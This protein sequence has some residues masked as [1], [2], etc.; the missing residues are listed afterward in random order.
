MCGVDRHRKT[1][2]NNVY[3]YLHPVSPRQYPNCKWIT[4]SNYFGNRSL[5]IRSGVV[6]TVQIY[7]IVIHYYD[8]LEAAATEG[9]QSAAEDEQATAGE[10][11]PA[12]AEGADA[13]QQPAAA[14]ETGEKTPA[15]AE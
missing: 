15:P 12:A 7:C 10:D 3:S 13:E 14:G 9:E 8:M 4:V 2:Y 11:K 1:S 6:R 5:F